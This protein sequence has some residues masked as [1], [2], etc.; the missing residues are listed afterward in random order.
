MS[1][2]SMERFEYLWLKLQAIVLLV[3]GRNAAALAVFDRMVARWS[4][5]VYALASRAH[6]QTQANRLTEALAD[7]SRLVVLRADHA[8][9]WFNHGFMLEAAGDGC[10]LDTAEG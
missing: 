4:D 1:R 2:F 9:T 10:E 8:A 5:D 7:S 3:L 6:L